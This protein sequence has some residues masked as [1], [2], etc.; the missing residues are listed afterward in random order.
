MLSGLM[1]I[2]T[3]IKTLLLLV[4]GCL[5]ISSRNEKGV[6]GSPV[7]IPESEGWWTRVQ[8]ADL[9]KDGDTDFILGNWGLNTKFKASARQT[10]D[11]VC[12]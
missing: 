4:T 6:L 3:E 9:D 1:L 8:A 7:I 2:P 5:C 10:I 11:N 12:E